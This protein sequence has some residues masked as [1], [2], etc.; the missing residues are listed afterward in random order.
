MDYINLKKLDKTFTEYKNKIVT[1][2]E[3]QCNHIQP[4]IDS[5]TDTYSGWKIGVN[6]NNEDDI[7]KDKNPTNK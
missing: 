1:M 7:N 6:S 4:Y 3:T 2:V 5:Y